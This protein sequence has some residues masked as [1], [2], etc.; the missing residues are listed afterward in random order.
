[1]EIDS[2]YDIKDIINYAKDDIVKLL[3]LE[4]KYYECI[5]VEEVNHILIIHEKKEKRCHTCI[6]YNDN[7]CI[8]H[9]K[10]CFYD[11]QGTYK[12][13]ICNNYKS[14]PNTIAF[15][16]ETADPRTIKSKFCHITLDKKLESEIFG[17][18]RL[19]F[20]F[21]CLKLFVKRV[22]DNR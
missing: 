15:N 19:G 17:N 4:D 21:E 7:E 20:C 12:D 5:D 8:F 11:L 1:M 6:Y 22:D 13:N 9:Y 3:D 10:Q 14:E 16:P 18:L 2:I